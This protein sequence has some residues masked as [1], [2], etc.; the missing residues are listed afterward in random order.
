[1]LGVKRCAPYNDGKSYFVGI[2]R[3]KAFPMMTGP[4]CFISKKLSDDDVIPAPQIE[5]WLK[6]CWL[7]EAQKQEF[8][9]AR[10]HGVDTAAEKAEDSNS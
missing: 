1:M 3:A 6:R 4:V 7:T 8:W 2:D 5:N 10:S 9:L